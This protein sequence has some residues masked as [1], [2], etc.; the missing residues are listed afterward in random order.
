MLREDY[1]RE[2][3]RVSLSETRLEEMIETMKQKGETPV[4]TA[5][6][7][8]RT[9][10]TIAAACAALAVSVSA[11]T[12]LGAF[13]F[14]REQ[15]AFEAMGLTEVYEA[16]AYGVDVTATT[17]GGDVFTLEK[18]A[19]D[20]TFLT[21]FYTYRYAEPLMT[22]A[23]FEALDTADSWAPYSA[24]PRFTLSLS[25]AGTEIS[26]NGYNNSFEPQ[27]YFSDPQ[28]VRGAWRCLLTAPLRETAAGASLTLQGY[29]CD[30]EAKAREDFSVEFTAQLDPSVICTPDVTFPLDWAG[31]NID[32]HVDSVK[33]S[34]LGSLLTLRYDGNENA[35]L[36]ISGS[37]VLRDKDTGKYIPFARVW[38]PSNSGGTDQV[39]DTYELFGDIHELGEINDL[40][41]VPIR[42]AKNASEQKVVPLSDLPSSDSG[43]PAGGYA[44]ASYRVSGNRLIVELQPVGAVSAEEAALLNGVYFLDK[45]GNELFRKAATE[46]FKNRQTGVITVIETVRDPVEL[47]E[48]VGKVDAL[49]FFVEDYSLLEDKA[50]T[51]PIL[52]HTDWT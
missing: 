12:L 4:K 11:A 42:S 28:T 32:I 45:D 25:D 3:D 26:Q 19:T 30:P 35:G 44:P 23:E 33:I 31:K 22:Q 43:N 40:E 27:Q 52:G 29:T 51:I 9:A 14:L 2:M 49:W 17:P 41:L 16:Y 47:A 5:R 8:W 1:R 39:V 13:D 20:G 38:T 36:G 24:A 50:V 34:P 21:I 15:D 7:T 6:K 48:N 18:A 46:K 37:F 10:L